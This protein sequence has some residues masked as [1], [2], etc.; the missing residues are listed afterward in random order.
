MPYLCVIY[1][2]RTAGVQ[3]SNAP[4]PHHYPFVNVRNILTRREVASSYAVSDQLGMHDSA[5]AD[6]SS[7]KPVTPLEATVNG[8]ITIEGVGAV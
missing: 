8:L 6:H 1:P 3:S 7:L 2:L 4:N 5:G